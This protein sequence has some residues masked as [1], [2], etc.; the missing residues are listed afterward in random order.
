ME[1]GVGG[2]GRDGAGV[3]ENKIKKSKKEKQE[4]FKLAPEI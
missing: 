1:V 3:R 2:W 4:S